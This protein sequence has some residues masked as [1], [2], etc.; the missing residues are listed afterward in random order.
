MRSCWF[1]SCSQR[2]RRLVRARRDAPAN[3]RR[4]DRERWDV[5]IA[6]YTMPKFSGTA[7]LELV[8][9]RFD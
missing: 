1:A 6:D 5:V 8:R 3:E 7:A 9:S 2:L 4:V